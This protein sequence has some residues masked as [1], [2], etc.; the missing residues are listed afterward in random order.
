LQ[1][2][3]LYIAPYLTTDMPKTFKE[4]CRKAKIPAKVRAY[5]Y[6]EDITP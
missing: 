4:A 5:Y 1:D 6:Q 3:L 2:N